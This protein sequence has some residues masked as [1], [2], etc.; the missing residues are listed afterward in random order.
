LLWE[1]A[2]SLRSLSKIPNALKGKDE[3]IPPS[4]QPREGG[5][6]PSWI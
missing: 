2:P 5:G 6:K 1:R 3:S 4:G